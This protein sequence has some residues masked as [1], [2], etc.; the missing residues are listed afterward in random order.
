MTVRAGRMWDNTRSTCQ[1]SLD[2][3]PDLGEGQPLTLPSNCW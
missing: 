2:L 1:E 3:V